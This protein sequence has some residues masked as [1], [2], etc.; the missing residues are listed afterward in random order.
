MNFSGARVPRQWRRA[1]AGADAAAC[2][3][4]PQCRVRA[5][6]LP[7]RL[8]LDARLQ[9]AAGADIGGLRR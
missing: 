9:C 6:P 5:P 2:R 3:G 1:L 4:V 7:G 8:F